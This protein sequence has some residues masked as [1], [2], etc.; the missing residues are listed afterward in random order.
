[1]C[2]AVPIPTGTEPECV[3]L[4]LPTPDPHKLRQAAGVLRNEAIAVLLALLVGGTN[5]T[6]P[7]ETATPEV[8][9]H[10]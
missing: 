3:A 8:V 6:P 10:R 9:I 1:M 5:P 7:R 4:S 2:A